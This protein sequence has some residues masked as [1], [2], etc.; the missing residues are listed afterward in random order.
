[1]NGGDKLRAFRDATVLVLPSAYE[2]FGLVPF[3]AMLCG[4]PTIVTE[5][6]GC[7]EIV[8][9]SRFGQV[10]KYGDINGLKDVMAYTI[11]N[12]EECRASAKRGGQ[13]VMENLTWE[14]SVQRFEEAYDSCIYVS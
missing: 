7:S 8:K 3:E 2:I 10:I 13:Y 9:A 12:I 11:E 1:M 14:K 5:E 6:C 4:T